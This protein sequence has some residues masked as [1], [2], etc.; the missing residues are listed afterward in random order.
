[1]TMREE[2]LAAW[3]AW[4]EAPTGK[5]EAQAMVDAMTALAL[6]Y[7]LPPATVR[8]VLLAFRRAGIPRGVCMDAFIAGA[9]LVRE[10][11]PR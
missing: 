11:V 6:P 8:D 4:D 3:S 10:R 1:M 7:A 9:Q 5:R 2:T